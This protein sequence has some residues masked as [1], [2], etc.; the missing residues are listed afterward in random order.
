ME[1]KKS[2]KTLDIKISKLANELGVSRPTLDNYIEL[3][4]KGE[5]IPNDVYQ[6]I[7][8]YL[9]SKELPS[10][11]EFAKKY[12][13][14]KRVLLNNVSCQS[15]IE[16]ID[17]KENNLKNSII[18]SINNDPISKELLEFV[19]M[20]LENSDND[21]VNAI[22]MYFNYSNGIVNI[23]K[24]EV[25]EKN[26]ALF[27]QLF[28]LFANYKN[29][30]ISFDETSYINFLNKNQEQFLKKNPSVSDDEIIEYIKKNIS[31]SDSIDFDLLKHMIDSR[32]GN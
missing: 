28:T 26:K 12:D 6:Q 17:N 7:F 27:S 14:A 1:I 31:N 4:E 9:F 24:T 11:I 29:E 18:Y 13:Y 15:K 23:T 25:C 20:F 5:K 3:Y 30:S 8:E 22:Y 21:L 16:S 2:L 32:E 10:S 19:N